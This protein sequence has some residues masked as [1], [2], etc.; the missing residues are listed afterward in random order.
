[1]NSE[2]NFSESQLAPNNFEN[3]TNNLNN[4]SSRQPSTLLKFKSKIDLQHASVQG[5]FIEQE[6]SLPRAIS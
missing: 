3:A 5:K 6:S 1:L 2:A 4:L